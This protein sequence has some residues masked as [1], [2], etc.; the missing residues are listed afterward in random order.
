MLGPPKWNTLAASTATVLALNHAG[1]TGLQ[2]RPRAWNR[3]GPGARQRLAGCPVVSGPVENVI[4]GARGSRLAQ[5]MVQELIT[6]IGAC[7]VVR[8]RAR[9][10]MTDGD[11]DRKAPVRNLGGEGGVFTT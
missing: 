1:P 10:V 3:A 7:P 2:A 5:A 6:H 9:S 4:V 11:R 8:F